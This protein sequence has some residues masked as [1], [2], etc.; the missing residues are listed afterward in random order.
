LVAQSPNWQLQTQRP[1][2]A[3]EL[4]ADSARYAYTCGVALHWA[5][6][7]QEAIGQLKESL[8][9][10][11]ESRDIVMAIVSFSRDAGDAATALQYA[12]KAARIAPEDPAIR[13]MV[14]EVRRQAAPR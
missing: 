3:A 13:A 14:E 11:P 10:H 6:R 5:G 2:R 12:E 4:D 9:R 1:P 7:R 8:A